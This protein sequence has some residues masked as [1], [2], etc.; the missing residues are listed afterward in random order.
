MRQ[1][2]QQAAPVSSRWWPCQRSSETAQIWTSVDSTPRTESRLKSAVIEE[3]CRRSAAVAVAG[4][5]GDPPKALE[6]HPAVARSDRGRAEADGAPGPPSLLRSFGALGWSASR[7]SRHDR[8]A[9]EGW[10]ARPAFHLHAASERSERATRTE[11]AGEA[12]RESAWRGVRG[13]KP[14]G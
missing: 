13:A 3:P 1:L 6:R 12:A 4:T 10:R 5:R 11:R 14:L 2:A 9:R 7:S 8:I